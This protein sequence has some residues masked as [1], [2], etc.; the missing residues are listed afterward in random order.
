[1]PIVTP[2][3]LPGAKGGSETPWWE[4]AF[5]GLATGLW[6]IPK[7]FASLGAEIYDLVGDH[8]TA[9]EVDKWF[10][11]VNPFHEAAEA[12]TVGKIFEAIAQL[13]PIGG[14]GGALGRMAGSALEKKI[15]TIAADALAAKREGKYLSMTNV[16]QKLTN[17]IGPT[18]GSLVG[19]ALGEALVA[20]PNIGTFGDLFQGTSLEPYAFTMMNRDEKPEDREDAARRLINRLKFGTETGLVGLA[21]HGAGAGVKKIINPTGLPLEE[22]S[23]KGW[24]KW[25]QQN[26][27][28]GYYGNLDPEAF[29]A[30]AGAISQTKGTRVG[31]LEE[32]S[33]PIRKAFDPIMEPLAKI[34]QTEINQELTPTLELL[35]NQV[36]NNVEKKSVDFKEQVT[37]LQAGRQRVQENVHNILTSDKKNVSLFNPKN[38]NDKINEYK[39]LENTKDGRKKL[40]TEDLG[41]NSFVTQNEK[42][43]IVIVH[44]QLPRTPEIIEKLKNNEIKQL[45]ETLADGSKKITYEEPLLSK[46]D[47]PTFGKDLDEVKKL[48]PTFHNLLNKVESV[49]GDTDFIRDKLIDG[50]YTVDKQIV[51]SMMIGI[52]K[53]QFDTIKNSVGSYLTSSFEQYNKLNPLKKNVATDFQI[54]QATSSLLKTRIENLKNQFVKSTGKD[55][56]EFQFELKP[57]ETPGDVITRMK[58]EANRDV[59]NYIEKR[60]AKEEQQI[61]QVPDE[62]S[63]NKLDTD[64]YKK[65]TL[66]D[67]K[68]YVTSGGEII[69]APWNF[70]ETTSRLSGVNNA[71]KALDTIKDSSTKAQMVES[72]ERYKGGEI[73]INP[74]T[75]EPILDQRTGK[76]LTYKPNEIVTPKN[77]QI[78]FIDDAINRNEIS[79]EQ[80]LKTNQAFT[81]DQMDALIKKGVIS[82]GDLNNPL[83]FKL[84]K[85]DLEISGLNPFEGMYVKAPYYDGIFDVSSNLLNKN[86]LGLLYKYMILGPKTISQAAKTV[87]SPVTHARNFVTASTFALANGALFP[88]YGDIKQLLPEFLGGEGLNVFALNRKKLLGT[89]TADEAKQF[90]R[91][92]N[93]DVIRSQVEAGQL[94]DLARDF[95][96]NPN[97]VE[98][99][100]INKLNGKVGQGLNNIYKKAEDIY[101]TEDDF[102]KMITWNLERNRYSKIFD[103]S[104]ENGGMGINKDNYRN[105]LLGNKIVENRIQPLTIDEFNSLPDNLK[106]R[107]KIIGPQGTEITAD[108]YK[109]LTNPAKRQSKFFNENPKEVSLD[110]YN[111]LTPNE[112]VEK[113][114]KF[115]D[116]NGRQITEKQYAAEKPIVDFFN[117]SKINK[118]YALTSYDNF[119]D[120]YAGSRARHQI[121][122]YSYV[123]K[124]GK[125]MRLSPFGNFV[126]FPLEIMRTGNNIYEQAIKEITSGIPQ[127]KALGI[128]RLMSFGATIGGIPIGLQETMKGLNNVSEDEMTALRRIVPEWSKNST[129][130]PW[131]RD[132]KGYLKY[133]D[134]DYANPYSFLL[135]PYNAILGSVMQ[136]VEDKESLL[137]GLGKGMIEGTRDILKPFSSESLWTEALVD[138]TLRNG[139]G[140]NGK[141]V[142]NEED[143]HFVKIVKSLGHLANSLAPGSLQQAKRLELAALGKSDEYG[144]TFDLQDELP[145]LYGFRTIKSDPE[146]ALKFKAT[147]FGSKLSRDVGLFESPLLKGGR[148][149]P[150]DIIDRYQYAETRR[151]EN[152]KEMYGDIE[153]L[154][155]LGV[156]DRIIKENLK[157]KKGIDQKTIDAIMKGKFSPEEPSK[158]FVDK[159]DKINK[160]LNQKE[161]EYLPN[162][163]REAFPVIN[164]L[165]FKNKG[166]KLLEDNINVPFSAL[167]T[168]SLTTASTGFILPKPVIP[169]SIG[170]AIPSISNIVGQNIG[171]DNLT[172]SQRMYLSQSE[173]EYEKKRQGQPVQTVAGR[174]V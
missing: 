28:F 79:P 31:T 145:G 172:N 174:T 98:T 11:D 117:D 143:D 100:F 30:K 160:D 101:T 156:T 83:K 6:N 91:L 127:V 78:K 8:H 118:D 29:A 62:I 43:E 171:A 55:I 147:A 102:W 173:Q 157:N 133:K 113:G 109:S 36:L 37:S 54:A 77:S 94:S 64:I 27:T 119:L 18:S 5:A 92:L 61:G 58:D 164:N 134:F 124:A 89:L 97:K 73:K 26:F 68:K 96:L 4:S 88:N 149:T 34:A 140:I 25:L 40:I 139:V 2:D 95:I 152:M 132:E 42:G 99:N 141:R 163:Y 106:S 112:R 81:K 142:Y 67:W 20:D 128:R 123:A 65:E 162:P 111:K 158:S 107:M 86:T 7:G 3:E 33:N 63:K 122:N 39:L 13:A 47:Y 52:D 85:Q 32:I 87:F 115:V 75:G 44:N 103:S 151:F 23:D 41:N 93:V 154:R 144:K 48:N 121:P 105:I 120:E 59:L 66:D 35:N 130:I 53:K 22:Y 126:A 9:K 137:R 24:L 72:L 135:K 17:L 153:A 161:G 50:R 80:F 110:E 155:K 82:E 104:I 15:G 131:G 1:M 16:G 46:Q 108:Q 138:S 56:S 166:L 146:D 129:L 74:K 150:Q 69:N 169:E 90:Q 168:G 19:T 159:L 136:G 76:P 49:G 125:T 12:R 57:G 70:L 51:R 84:V 71:R 114:L 60:T 10:D 14:V 170:S 148:V 45:T 38:F 167:P 165:I 21:F 116:S